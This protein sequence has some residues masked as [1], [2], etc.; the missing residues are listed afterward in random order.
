M[1]LPF[2]LL[3][4]HLFMLQSV[5]WISFMSGI[6]IT[7]E[8][9]A[10]PLTPRRACPSAATDAAVQC[11][12]RK[13]VLRDQLRQAWCSAVV[14]IVLCSR[15]RLGFWGWDT[16]VVVVGLLL[17]R[18]QGRGAGGGTDVGVRG[19]MERM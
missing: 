6:V 10:R 13:G 11:R 16:N 18:A 4:S 9:C 5:L 15:S 8:K 19:L 12:Y 17:S 1:A 2:M 3:D 14:V 7:G